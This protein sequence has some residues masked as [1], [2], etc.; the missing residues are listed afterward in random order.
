MTTRNPSPEI[1]LA[2]TILRCLKGIVAAIEAYLR[3]RK[4][5]G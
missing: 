1:I 4:G 2:Q 3:E 5:E